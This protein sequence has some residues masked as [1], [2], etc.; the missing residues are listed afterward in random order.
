MNSTWTP[1]LAGLLILAIGCGESQKRLKIE[2][3]SGGGSGNAQAKSLNRADLT[4]NCKLESA[5][6]DADPTEIFDL[7]KLK[8]ALKEPFHA[9][10]IGRSYI[11][12][13]Q[14]FDS[15]QYS[16]GKYVDI[17]DTNLMAVTIE[18]H[19]FEFSENRLEKLIDGLNFSQNGCQRVIHAD[20]NGVHAHTIDIANSDERTLA[21]TGP[22]NTANKIQ[23][24]GDTKFSFTTER[25]IDITKPCGVIESAVVRI[26]RILEFGSDLKSQ[27]NLRKE[28]FDVMTSMTKFPNVLTDNS[29]IPETSA[30]NPNTVNLDMEVFRLFDYSVKNKTSETENILGVI[31]A[32]CEDPSEANQTKGL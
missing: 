5:E 4:T 24:L 14:L 26:T 16:E 12:S 13:I 31:T 28:L 7:E 18:H 10:T 22:Q 29:V 15:A 1:L 19:G 17:K 6:K 20:K 32:T 21:F 8:A 30:R 27:I 25:V 2:D 3:R 23:A 11:S 9:S